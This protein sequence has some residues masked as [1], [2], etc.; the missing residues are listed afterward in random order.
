MKKIL[1]SLSLL[2]ATM[3]CAGGLKVGYSI[4]DITPPLG[5]DMPG[6]YKIRN[7]KEVLDP[8]EIVCVAFSDGKKTAFVMQIDAMAISDQGIVSPEQSSARNNEQLVGLHT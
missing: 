5:S 1:F 6:Y 3:C 7:L 2:A 8:L 4:K